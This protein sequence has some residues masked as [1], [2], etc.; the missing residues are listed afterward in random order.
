LAICRGLTNNARLAAD[1]IGMRAGET[2]VNPMLLFHITCCGLL[3]LGPVQSTDTHVLMPRF[4]PAL[5]LEFT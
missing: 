1:A 2:A 4:D 3:T 5:Q